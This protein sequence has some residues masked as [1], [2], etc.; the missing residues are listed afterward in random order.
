MANT[1]TPIST[2]TVGSGGASSIDF[3]SISQS[4]TDLILKISARTS[5]SGNVLDLRIRVGNGNVDTG[6]NYKYLELTG[7]PSASIVAGGGGTT[8]KFNTIHPGSSVTASTF[9]SVEVYVPNYA[10]SDKKSMSTDAITENNSSNTQLRLQAWL[11]DSTSTINTI[12][13]FPSS[14]TFDQYSTATLYGIKNS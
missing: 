5:A 7:I 14:G 9:G 1:Y 12:S 2:V 13:I 10:S 4:Y 3:T 11:W 8:D 6:S